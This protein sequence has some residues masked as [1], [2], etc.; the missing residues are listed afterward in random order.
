MRPGDPDPT[1]LLQFTVGEYITPLTV[2]KKSVLGELADI[3]AKLSDRYRLHPADAATF[4]LTGRPPEVVVISTGIELRMGLD[5]SSAT[6]I[7]L[8]IDP[9]LPVSQ[10]ADIYGQLRAQLHGKTARR[11]LSVKHLRLAAHVGPHLDFSINNPGQVRRRGRPPKPSARNLVTNVMPG[12]GHTWEGLR[13]SWNELYGAH[14]EEGR[15]W[16]YSSP[17]NFIRDARHAVEH[18]L[19]PGWMP[20]RRPDARDVEQFAGEEDE[21]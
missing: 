17:T 14:V 11:A 1:A 8:V 15:S 2:V 4:V 13:R 19:D 3:A 6:R 21:A 20:I 7:T 16:L 5:G 18:V 12:G 10:V 9:T